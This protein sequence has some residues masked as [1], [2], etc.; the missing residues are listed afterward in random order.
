MKRLDGKRALITGAARGI[1]RAFAQRYIREGAQ[2]AIAD[3]DL[4]RV[5]ITA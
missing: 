4:D 3:I 5:Q 2:V 1:G